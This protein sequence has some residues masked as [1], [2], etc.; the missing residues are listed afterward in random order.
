ML[1]KNAMLETI[2][3][4]ADEKMVLLL[5]T[6]AMSFVLR[7]LFLRAEDPKQKVEAFK[8]TWKT[9]MNVKID[10]SVNAIND[11]LEGD[12]PVGMFLN[13]LSGGEVDGESIRLTLKKKFD[14]YY[15]QVMPGIEMLA[16]PEE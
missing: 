9:M 14:E 8:E 6:T 7:D 13:M 5:L 16:S 1:D 2:A 10:E 15:E 11:Q 4:D 12:N 3:N